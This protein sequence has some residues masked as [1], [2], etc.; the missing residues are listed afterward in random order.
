[1]LKTPILCCSSYSIEEFNILVI[2]Q[3]QSIIYSIVALILLCLKKLISGRDA[4]IA[5]DSS[6]QKPNRP[7]EYTIPFMDAAKLL[8]IRNVGRN[9]LIDILEEEKVIYR[10]DD[11]YLPMQKYMN[12]GY[13]KVKYKSI[14]TGDSNRNYI[15][16][17]LT[18]KGLK[19]LAAILAKRGYEVRGNLDVL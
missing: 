19:W 4:T 7:S 17:Y 10:Q 11:H 13:F 8:D 3:K 5:K 16:T 2:G 18:W 12:F 9:R 15:Q 6:E 14:P 1:M